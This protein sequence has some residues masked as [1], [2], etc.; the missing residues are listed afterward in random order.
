MA[1]A[2]R[3][4]ALHVQMRRS[5]GVTVGLTF[6]AMVPK[7]PCSSPIQNP[8]R[9]SSKPNDRVKSSSAARQG[10]SRST[11]GRVLR[12]ERRAVEIHLPRHRPVVGLAFPVVRRRKQ[13]DARRVAGDDRVGS[14]ALHRVV[15]V[16]QVFAQLVGDER[17]PVDVVG[18]GEDRAQAARLDLIPRRNLRYQAS[19][20]C[21]DRAVLLL[22]PRAEARH[23]VRAEAELRVGRCRWGWPS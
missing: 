22:Q 7:P 13:A 12:I 19:F 18:V 6:S 2:P 23:G 14:D 8:S 15:A 1:F 10:T 16:A 5:S 21:V 20:S 11:N 3:A 9:P 4:S 17:L